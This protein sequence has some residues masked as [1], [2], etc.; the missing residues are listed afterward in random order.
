[1]MSTPSVFI[2]LSFLLALQ[3][4]A[5]TALQFGRSYL[6]RPSCIARPSSV[7]LFLDTN[8]HSDLV[9]SQGDDEEEDEIPK[10]YRRRSIGWSNTY[11][12]I[13]PYE[14]ARQAVLKMGFISK[15]DWDE[16]VADG[17][18]NPYV[19]NHPDE[20]YANEWVSWDEFLGLRRSYEET[21]NMV[22]TVLHLHT[23]EEYTRFVREDTKRAEGLRIPL[24][25]DIV[26][27]E[28]GWTN[29]DDFFGTLE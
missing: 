29:A 25:P 1:M 27:R 12:R 3:A 5:T 28:R 7:R 17:R 19:P 16:S 26:Y 8:N 13:I 11:R 21:Q 10:P 4:S 18:V 22:Q 14:Q 23:L 24:K 2:I 20:M 9:Q 15:E 6:Q